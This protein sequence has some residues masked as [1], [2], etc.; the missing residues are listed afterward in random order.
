MGWG[1]RKSGLHHEAL[2]DLGHS[3][4]PFIFWSLW[5][6]GQVVSRALL[7]L[8]LWDSPESRE[9]REKMRSM[10][11]HACVHAHTDT[12]TG[13]PDRSPRRGGQKQEAPGAAEVLEEGG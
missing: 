4:F 3:L 5:K 8:S 6:L 12:D 2:N 1:T 11:L 13:V 7:V 9:G 10:C